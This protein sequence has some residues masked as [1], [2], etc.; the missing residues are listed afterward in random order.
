MCLSLFCL[1]FL[2]CCFVGT[3]LSFKPSGL[4][5]VEVFVVNVLFRVVLCLLGRRRREMNIVVISI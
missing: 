1:F 3:F 2:F 4:A 5:K